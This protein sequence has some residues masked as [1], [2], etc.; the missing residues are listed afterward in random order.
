M[1]E[2]QAEVQKRSRTVSQTLRKPA[3]D[4][5][6]NDRVP[7]GPPGQEDW[8]ETSEIRELR[9][10]DVTLGATTLALLTQLAKAKSAEHATRLGRTLLAS[11]GSGADRLQPLVFA[12]TE[13]AVALEHQRRLAGRDELTGVSNRRSFNESLKREVARARRS[14]RQLSLLMLD[15]DGLKSINDGLGHPAGD[16]AIQGVANACLTAVRDTDQ[17]ARLGGDE[18][19]V[20]LPDADGD[21]AATVG[22]RV[23]RRLAEQPVHGLTLEVSYGHA[24]LTAEQADEQALVAAADRALYRNKRARSGR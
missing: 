2:R 20:I 8:K 7:H 16:A 9:G 17:V 11:L 19:A 13:R 6:G 14:G 21:E 4:S 5:D 22:E 1:P 23:R 18:F 24:S 12:L 10:E 3:P 15:L